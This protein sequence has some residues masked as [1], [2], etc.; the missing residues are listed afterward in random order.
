MLIHAIDEIRRPVNQFLNMGGGIGNAIS[1][2]GEDRFFHVVEKLPH[3]VNTGVG[4]LNTCICNGND[5]SDKVEV[6]N[7][8]DVVFQVCRSVDAIGDGIDIFVATD[9]FQFTAGGKFFRNN[10]LVGRCICAVK[11]EESI[12]NQ[13][14]CRKIEGIGCD[15]FSNAGRN[16]V[17]AAV[18]D[19]SRKERLLTFHTKWRCPMN[20]FICFNHRYSSL[21]FAKQSHWQA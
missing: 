11:F 15:F 5:L 10:Q 20:T 8:L 16:A 13:T 4:I 18:D 7:A 2:N 9:L 3:I 21:K 12:V 1:R 19:A 17:L 6:P 14:M